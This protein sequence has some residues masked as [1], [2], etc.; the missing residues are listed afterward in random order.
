MCPYF[1]GR[2][3]SQNRRDSSVALAENRFGIHDGMGAKTI[4]QGGVANS[5]GGKGDFV[6]YINVLLTAKNEEDVELIR[7]LLAEAAAL[8][9]TEPGCVRFDVFHSQSDARVFLLCECWESEA[10]WMEHRE[11]RAFREIYQPRVLPLVERVPH[12][13]T[14]VE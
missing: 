10:A 14:P 2:A 7:G 8:S 4:N 6:F 13:S 1:V 11:E 3:S 9:R 5:M 12:I